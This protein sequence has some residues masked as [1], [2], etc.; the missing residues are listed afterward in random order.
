ML[1]KK[2]LKNL[3]TGNYRIVYSEKC[4]C[5]FYWYMKDGNF[6]CDTIKNG[7]CYF[8]NLLIMDDLAGE[9]DNEICIGYKGIIATFNSY[10]GVS[11]QIGCHEQDIA[12]KIRRYIIN[13]TEIFRDLI[14]SL[15]FP[16]KCN[17]LHE[18]RR[19]KAFVK[20]L[21]IRKEMILW[22]ILLHCMIC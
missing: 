2:I 8:E 12:F 18:R 6:V 11:L 5:E 20:F 3:E 1:A 22:K 15:D 19:D 10:Y 9:V 13:D 17:E 4:D 14:A 16:D 7:G 21:G